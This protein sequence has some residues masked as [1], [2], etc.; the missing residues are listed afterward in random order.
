M[1]PKTLAKST[2]PVGYEGKEKPKAEAICRH[3]PPGSELLTNVRGQA[4]LSIAVIAPARS[5][6]ESALLCSPWRLWPGRAS[7]PLSGSAAPTMGRKHKKHKSDKHATEEYT[8]KPLKL[9]LKVGGSEITE[10][11]TASL[12]HESSVNED[13]S[14][15]DKHKEKKKKKKKKTEKEKRVTPDERKRRKKRREKEPS[16]SER[17]EEERS[18]SPARFEM[19]PERHLA[20]PLIKVEEH[21]TPFQEL[22]YQLLRQLQRKDPNAFFS[23]PVTDFIA[24]GY[25]LIIK[26]PMDFSSMKEKVKKNEY[27]NLEELK[28]D[29]KMM[30]ENAMIYN[31]PD[32]IYYKAARKL[33]HSGMKVLSQEKIQS[34]KHSIDFMQDLEKSHKQG[35]KL[36]AGECS[37]EHKRDD[38][39]IVW[40]TMKNE[41]IRSADQR[42]EDRR[43]EK[44]PGEDPPSSSCNVI[45]RELE[46]VDRV[47]EES[48]GKLTRRKVNSKFEFQRRKI[49]GTTTLGILNPVEPDMG[50]T[51][52]CPV[53]L[54]MMAGRLQSGINTLQGFKEDKRNKVI[55]VTYLNY[56]PFSS[57]APVYDSTCANLSKEDS[58]LV[59]S[60]YSNDSSPP[61]SFSVQQF[62]ASNED[63]SVNMVDNLLDSLTNG[64]HSKSLKELEL[65][66]D[67]HED[68]VRI[69]HS[70]ED[71]QVSSAESLQPLEQS[72]GR[73]D[74]FASLQSL[75]NAEPESAECKMFQRKLD[76]T[77]KLLQDLQQAQNERFGTRP[78]SAMICLL[79]PSIR[80]LLLAE[81]VTGNLKELAS[82]VTP[83]DIT[84]TAGIR[85]AMGISVPLE[86]MDNC[87]LDP[88]FGAKNSNQMEEM[89]ITELPQAEQVIAITR[90]DP[91]AVA[92]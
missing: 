63:Y 26:Q 34:L 55:P 23:F 40:E 71:T 49:D 37:E 45:D 53:K 52:Y 69:L 48:A 1:K 66:S 39:D 83:G 70:T 4:L 62:L 76:E 46:K 73:A 20:S 38:M 61:G 47:I 14:D 43:S 11:S 35:E 12:T 44:E 41:G 19:P 50:D 42:N 80:E 54:G 87:S 56:G 90:E 7:P 89:E 32:T 68:E 10:L 15:H 58:D 78:P 74:N 60:T 64:E 92:M 21:Q 18:R 59:Y 30:C 2:K 13:K 57:Y 33:L 72:C 6:A 22:L 9:V 51:N 91:V 65:S 31:R 36:R 86:M 88:L 24:P 84:S 77:T 79:G 67:N 82:Q 8:D 16:A 17:E 3:E 25:S 27:Q 28:G 81:K 29:F 75:I 85:K 5:I